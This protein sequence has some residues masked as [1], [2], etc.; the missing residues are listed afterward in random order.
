MSIGEPRRGN[1][2]YG[3][4]G[5]KKT[6]GFVGGFEEPNGNQAFWMLEA[7]LP[8]GPCVTSN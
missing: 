6:P 1:E 3:T 7:C 4:G 8:L 5:N 2:V